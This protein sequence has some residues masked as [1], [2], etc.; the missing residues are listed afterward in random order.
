M[1][2]DWID[3]FK[4]ALASGVVAAMVT[5]GL[6]YLKELRLLKASH[7]RDARYLAARV[8]IIFERFSVDCSQAI[9]GNE[10]HRQSGGSAG[11]RKLTMPKISELPADADWKVIEPRLLEKALSF[12][13]EIMLAD[14][15]IEFG[16]MS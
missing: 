8:A 14:S 5:V 13:T 12:P 9:T 11:A 16:G 10:L 15:K 4:V 1:T 2:L 7:L 3:I 6:T